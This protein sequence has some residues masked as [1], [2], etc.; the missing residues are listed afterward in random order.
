[1][2]GDQR[3]KRATGRPSATGATRKPLFRVTRLS[4][5]SRLSRAAILRGCWL[6]NPPSLYNAWR[7]RRWRRK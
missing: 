4:R 1:M 3:L 5:P 7:W 6:G 2:G